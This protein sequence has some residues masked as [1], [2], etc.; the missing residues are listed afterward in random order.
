V[1]PRRRILN[2][3]RQYYS[4][5]Y[6]ALSDTAR[7]TRLG[8]LNLDGAPLTDRDILHINRLS[9]L[10]ELSLARTGITDEA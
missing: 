2:F 8:T 7:F 9:C 10:M 3:G 6:E 5:L 1:L 4:N